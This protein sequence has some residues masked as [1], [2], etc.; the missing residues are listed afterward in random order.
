MGSTDERSIRC[1]LVRENV[2]SAHIALDISSQLLTEPS[3]SASGLI[4]E[5]L[6]V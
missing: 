4:V 6:G 2:I 3:A 1:F 5:W